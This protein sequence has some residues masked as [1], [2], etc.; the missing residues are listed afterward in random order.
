VR[1]RTGQTAVVSCAANEHHQLGGRMVADI[2]EANGWRG[3]FIGANL[4]AGNLLQLLREK[5]P[6]AVALSLALPFNLDP[7][8]RMAE[9]VRAEFPALPILV[10]GQGVDRAARERIERIE[11]ARCLATLVELEDWIHARTPAHAA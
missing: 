4:P 5:R 3:Y 6:D 2:F 7:L 10:G 1:P 9:A 8:V 11:G